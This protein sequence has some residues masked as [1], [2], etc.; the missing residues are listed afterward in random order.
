M[1]TSQTNTGTT[2]GIQARMAEIREESA[3]ARA[4]G[5]FRTENA[6]DGEMAGLGQRLRNLRPAHDCNDDRCCATCP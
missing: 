3:A 6:L 5:D 1:T 4:S 2:E